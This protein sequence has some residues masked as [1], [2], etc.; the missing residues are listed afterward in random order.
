MLRCVKYRKRLGAYM[1]GELSERKRTSTTRHLSECDLCRE[2]LESLKELN[3]FLNTLLVPTRPAALTT[4]ILAEA[5]KRKKT[6]SIIL[7]RMQWKTLVF[8]AWFPRAVTTAAL[9]LGLLSG[10]YMG[11]ISYRYAGTDQL[12]TLTEENMAV[13]RTW[14][15]LNALT[16]LSGDSIEA[17]TFAML[18]EN[19]GNY[20]E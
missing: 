2:E 4:R 11:S 1:D 14:S 20:V 7:I 8:D 10:E 13:D 15:E 6:S 9:V 12:E 16:V 18:E 5:Q 17:L 3:P 19:E